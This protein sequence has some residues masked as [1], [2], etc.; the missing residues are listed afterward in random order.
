MSALMQ[1]K[2]SKESEDMISHMLSKQKNK[3]VLALLAFL[4]IFSIGFTVQPTTVHADTTMLDVVKSMHK[5]RTNIQNNLGYGWEL[6]APGE[7]QVLTE[8]TRGLETATYSSL[9][10]LSFNSGSSENGVLSNAAEFAK[11]LRAVG[12]DK[13]YAGPQTWGMLKLIPA[14]ILIVVIFFLAM[15]SEIVNWTLK[16]V[17]AL[18]PITWLQTVFEAVLKGNLNGNGEIQVPDGYFKS[19]AQMIG[20]LL[21]WISNISS[22]V[23]LI[24]LIFS[25][26]GAITNLGH[27]SSSQMVAQRGPATRV[28]N[29]FWNFIKRTAFMVLIPLLIL[30]ASGELI[31]DLTPQKGDNLYV[32]EIAR[33]VY[34]S[35]VYFKG[36]AEKSNLTIPSGVNDIKI[37][38]SLVSD[39][40]VLAINAADNTANLERA[41]VIRDNR[42]ENAFETAKWL[43]DY[44]FNMWALGDDYGGNKYESFVKRLVR[45]QVKDKNEADNPI[46]WLTKSGQE[47]FG[48]NYTNFSGNA[49]RDS[50]TTSTLSANLTRKNGVYTSN[51]ASSLDVYG[52]F[53]YLNIRSDET[54]ITYSK[55]SE[56]AGDSNVTYHANV[57]YTKNGVYG[58]V[59]WIYMVFKGLLLCVVI[60]GLCIQLVKAVARSYTDFTAAA[61]LTPTGAH[62]GLLSFTNGVIALVLKVYVAFA[63]LIVTPDFIIGL[64]KVIE[65]SGK[66]VAEGLGDTASILLTN[67]NLQNPFPLGVGDGA[68]AIIRVVECVLIGGLTLALIGVGPTIMKIIESLMNTFMNRIHSATKAPGAPGGLKNTLAQAND[69]AHG[70]RDI[71]GNPIKPN[72]GGNGKDGKDGESNNDAND[73]VTGDADDGHETIGDRVK[74]MLAKPLGTLGGGAGAAWEAMKEGVHR[75]ADVGNALSRNGDKELKSRT[76]KQLENDIEDRKQAASTAAYNLMHGNKGQEKTA[77]FDKYGEKSKEAA[78]EREKMAHESSVEDISEAAQNT[79]S[80]A[81]AYEKATADLANIDASELDSLNGEDKLITSTITE[82]VEKII[83]EKEASLRAQGYSAEEAA[84]LARQEV[85]QEAQTVSQAGNMETMASELTSAKQTLNQS[86]SGMEASKSNLETAMSETSEQLSTANASYQEATAQ[87]A[88]AAQE[89]VAQVADLKQAEKAATADL[90]SSQIAYEDE[91]QKLSHMALHGST[92]EQIKSQQAHIANLRANGTNAKELAIAEDNL[93]AMQQPKVSDDEVKA[94]M[95]TVDQAERKSYEARNHLAHTQQAVQQATTTAREVARSTGNS[96]QMETALAAQEQ[97]GSLEAT[98][99]VQQ[100]NHKALSN[101]IEQAKAMQGHFKAGFV[102]QMATKASDLSTA[103]QEAQQQFQHSGSAETAREAIL[104]SS[105][106][107]AQIATSRAAAAAVQEFAHVANNQSAQVQEVAREATMVN[108]AAKAMSTNPTQAT[109]SALR[110]NTEQL[111]MTQNRTARAAERAVN[112]YAGS[113]V[114][115][116]SLT[117]A[118]TAQYEAMRHIGGQHFTSNESK[119]RGHSIGDAFARGEDVKTRQG[120]IR[121]RINYSEQD[122]GK[123]MEALHHPDPVTRAEARKHVAAELSNKTYDLKPASGRFVS[124]TSSGS[125]INNHDLIS[126]LEDIQRAVV[127]GDMKTA[128]AVRKDLIARGVS[129]HY[130]ASSTRMAKMYNTLRTER[131]QF[132]SKVQQR[133]T[134]NASLKWADAAI[135]SGNRR[136]ANEAADTKAAFGKVKMSSNQLSEKD[137]PPPPPDNI[138]EEFITIPP[139]DHEPYLRDEV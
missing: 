29:A 22:L 27:I 89:A 112:T 83:E 124:T 136:Q 34:S 139:E 32:R 91:V 58:W 80:L 13:S 1:T 75:I 50:A 110:S 36:W 76:Q 64:V 128:K 111:T 135:A 4:A 21:Y 15:L 5:H 28:L 20:T 53:N 96:R 23:W 68:M 67:L 72:D 93:V 125:R 11:T 138:P 79:E 57:V 74:S 129:P 63:M 108:Q 14:G 94:Q 103:A 87:M 69:Y 133:M 95:Q 120:D 48:T 17:I 10:N 97:I 84:D 88:P 107:G 26:I 131:T 37:G 118:G 82:E 33:D 101:T 85:L 56:Y 86:V 115:N 44:L 99:R 116:I 121:R 12:L 31:K 45:R 30:T 71:E 54:S 98:Q 55:N 132:A 8:S 9:D 126:G 49:A 117:R 127:G 114:R 6:L 43:N 40:T 73:L 38:A 134:E 104:A 19:I 39:D 42:N 106:S 90:A 60:L 25:I 52:M 119:Q 77:E 100:D 46:D 41:K 137:F 66:K 47:P 130:L 18:N 2:R 59:H 109:A 102:K 62:I 65:D 122:F 123:K 113:T 16:L 81:T 51:N 61:F 70:R 3:I 35:Y 92:P 24:I 105:R 7:S 78:L